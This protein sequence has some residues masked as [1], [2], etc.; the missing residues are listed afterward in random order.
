[1]QSLV[2]YTYLI[3]N[4]PLSLFHRKISAVRQ[5]RVK[6]IYPTGTSLIISINIRNII[7]CF[8]YLYKSQKK[9]IN[10]ELKY[11]NNYLLT[12]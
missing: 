2:S 7:D 1:M 10:K 8:S 11:E 6:F 9:I 12:S 3:H 4:L 5:L